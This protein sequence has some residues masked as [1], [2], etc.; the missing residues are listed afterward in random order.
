MTDLNG[1]CACG[2]AGF[3]AKG[4][5]KFAFICQCRD[6]QLNTGSDH[7]AQFCHAA[8]ALDAHGD[9]TMW[10]KPG[11]S[12]K[13]VNKHFCPTCGTPLYVT[14]DVAPTI[15][16]A[17]AGVLDDP[18]QLSPDRIFFADSKISWDHA[19]VPEAQEG[20]NQ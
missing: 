2:A 20:T 9:V 7:A 16:M 13:A 4:D 1:Q 8:D 14:L 19:S 12:G 15:I 5:P 10:S 18:N 3:T 17:S 11:G 6:C